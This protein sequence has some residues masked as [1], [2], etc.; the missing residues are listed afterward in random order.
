MSTPQ[1]TEHQKLAP[2]TS[3]CIWPWATAEIQEPVRSNAFPSP[4]L[5][6]S[7]YGRRIDAIRK[8]QLTSERHS[9]CIGD[10]WL[11]IRKSILD[12]RQLIGQESA[13]Q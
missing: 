6:C 12:T 2:E 11:R 10:V 1:A 9:T 13:T 8:V 5:P 4:K 7:N 3:S